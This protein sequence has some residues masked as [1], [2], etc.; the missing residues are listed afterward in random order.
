MTAFYMLLLI[1]LILVTIGTI[2]IFVDNFGQFFTDS[3]ANMAQ[4]T[5]DALKAMPYIAAVAVVA[6]VIAVILLLLEVRVK[7]HTA[8]IAG[9][10]CCAVLSILFAVLSKA[11]IK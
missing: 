3:T 11:V 6:S 10:I 4:F 9:A 8:K 7:K 1:M 2:F 5:E